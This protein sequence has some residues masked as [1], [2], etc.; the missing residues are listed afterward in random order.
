MRRAEFEKEYREAFDEIH[1]SD[2]LRDKVLNQKKTRLTIKPFKAT[3]VTVA[4][5]VMIFAVVHDYSFQNNGDG[6]IEETHTKSQTTPIPDGEFSAGE[7]AHKNETKD[8]TETVKTTVAP[9]KATEVKYE[10]ADTLTVTEPES[11]PVTIDTPQ[12]EVSVASETPVGYV[13]TAGGSVGQE[14]SVNEYFTY[15]G[16]NVDMC[17]ASVTEAVR[18]SDDVVS[19]EVDADKIVVSDI[20]SFD[21]AIGESGSA[22]IR[23]SKTAI[24]DASLSGIVNVLGNGISAYKVSEGVYYDVFATNVEEDTVRAIINTL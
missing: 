1:A 21:Y 12:E 23:T 2:S 15:I 7:S 13:R 6:I 10:D 5:A 20:Q 24:F 14:W 11:A 3:L 8:V 9:K 19:V 22:S 17:V 16:K 4:A 18:M